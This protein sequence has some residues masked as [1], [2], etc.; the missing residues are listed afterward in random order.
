MYADH[1][2]ASVRR[3]LVA[4]EGVTEVVCSAA[5]R[6]VSLA[7]DASRQNP[8]GLE[9]ALGAL[10]YHAGQSEP[11]FADA[12]PL[13]NRHTAA[14]AGSPAFLHQPPDWQGRPLWPCPGF[15]PTPVPDE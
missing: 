12:A 2:V 13:P 10:G 5:S 6:R 4:L 14:P 9:A 8:A 11:T 15:A 1:H 7:Y 3:T